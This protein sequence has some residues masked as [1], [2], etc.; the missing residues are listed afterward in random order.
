MTKLEQHRERIANLRVVLLQE[1]A[2][3]PNSKYAQ[4]LQQ[5]IN[6]IELEMKQLEFAL[7]NP[8]VMVNE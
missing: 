7:A 8:I 3:H 5:T 4:D 1:Q 2:I 6:F